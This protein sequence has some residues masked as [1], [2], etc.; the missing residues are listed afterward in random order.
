[1]RG[2]YRIAAFAL[3]AVVQGGYEVLP[4]CACPKCW[5][6]GDDGITCIP[7]A[8]K[9]KTFCGP[10]SITVTIDECVDRDTHDFSGT[11]LY[12]YYADRSI[13]NHKS[14]SRR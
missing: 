13:M 8:G 1:M 3:I 5:T 11:N 7:S 10:N 12:F 6:L 14:L 9:V 4:Y 2:L